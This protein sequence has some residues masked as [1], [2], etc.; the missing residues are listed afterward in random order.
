[1]AVPLK[2]DSI[3]LGIVV[4]DVEKALAFYRDTL[5][6]TFVATPALAAMGPGVMHLLLCGTTM[7]KLVDPGRPPEAKAAHR[8]Q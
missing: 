4:A 7:I 5:G 1:M 8:R 2:K 6:F 3:D